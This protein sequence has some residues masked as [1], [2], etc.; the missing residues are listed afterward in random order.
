MAYIDKSSAS[1]SRTT[2]GTGRPAL[3]CM[4]ATQRTEEHCRVLHRS[5]AAAQ[6]AIYTR[7]EKKVQ[8]EQHLFILRHKAAWNEVQ[9]C[10]QDVP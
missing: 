6:N 7:L 5:R 2:C 9:E 4:L 1:A 10:C 8:M 3:C